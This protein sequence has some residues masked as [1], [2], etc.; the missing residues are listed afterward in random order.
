MI[1]LRARKKKIIN[2]EVINDKW[3]KKAI[4]FKNI[5]CKDLLCLNC[6]YSIKSKCLTGYIRN[7]IDKLNKLSHN[8]LNNIPNTELAKILKDYYKQNQ[9]D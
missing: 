5:I 3:I 8:E 7:N 1:N 9:K 4:A 6:C 2:K